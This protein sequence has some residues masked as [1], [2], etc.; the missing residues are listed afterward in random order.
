MGYFALKIFIT[1]ILAKVRFGGERRPAFGSDSPSPEINN[2]FHLFL[3]QI[4]QQ[5]AVGEDGTRAHQ[6]HG[7]RR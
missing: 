4:I 7:E 2:L 5:G 3:S 1:A 6:R